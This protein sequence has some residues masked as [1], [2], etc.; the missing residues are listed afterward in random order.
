MI[1]LYKQIKIDCSFR[2]PFSS[3]LLL[4][5]GFSSITYGWASIAGV[6]QH[7][8]HFRDLCND[9]DMAWKNS[10]ANA[11]AIGQNVSTKSVFDFGIC[12]L[13]SKRFNLIFTISLVFV[14]GSKFT[15]AL[16][17]DEYGSRAGQTVRG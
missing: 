8:G 6:F 9:G 14:C 12:S 13:Q 4:R 2:L 10:T 5:Y 11:P 15:I 1:F 7:E 3:L 17:I 16:F